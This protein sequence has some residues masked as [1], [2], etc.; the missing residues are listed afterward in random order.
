MFTP[1]TPPLPIRSA[2][3][4]TFPSTSETDQGRQPKRL[5]LSLNSVGHLIG[6]VP[7]SGNQNPWVGVH[8]TNRQEQGNR[9]RISSAAAQVRQRRGPAGPGRRRSSPPSRFPA[10]RVLSR[11]DP[12]D[13]R[14]E[15]PHQRQAV[16]PAG[17]PVPL[18]VPVHGH[19]QDPVQRIPRRPVQ[20]H[21]LQ[22]PLRTEP[23]D[24]EEMAG[25]RAPLP[26]VPRVAVTFPTVGGPGQ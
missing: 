6:M 16:R 1:Y 11:G 22:E 14:R 23:F 12:G 17:R 4:L 20:A 2:R 25:L 24:G 3:P 26:L 19:V 10:H 21:R 18:P 8:K 13:V 9:F 5:P 15:P 7:A